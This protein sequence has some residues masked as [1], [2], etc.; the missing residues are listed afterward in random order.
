MDTTFA[1]SC[2]TNCFYYGVDELHPSQFFI[3]VIILKVTGR[4]RA[5]MKMHH[6]RLTFGRKL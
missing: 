6:K 4:Y 1:L 2:N 3:K 5:E